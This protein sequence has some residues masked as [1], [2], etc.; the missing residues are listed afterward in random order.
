M[1]G[2]IC[3]W[4]GGFF[5]DN[6]L[7]RILHKPERILAPYV[8]PG[9]TAVDFGCGWGLF[10]LALAELVGEQG[11]VISVD[12]Q[13][14]MLGIVRRRAEKAGLSE[15]V[16]TH[17][18]PKDSIALDERADFILAFWSAHET[19]DGEHLLGEFHACL[20]S[21]GRLLVAEPKVHVT[22]KAFDKMAAA[23]ERAGL[24]LESRPAIRASW[25]ATFM[26]A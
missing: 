20:N 3:P 22:R 2:H 10:T 12:L 18:S 7:R 11:R 8:K 9:M 13:D 19:P 23:A 17:R 26:K 15:R 4:W 16:H 25:A 14:K 24:T 6:P 21:G 5:I 1:A